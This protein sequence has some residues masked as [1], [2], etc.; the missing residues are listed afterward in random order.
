[1]L[2]KLEKKRRYY[3]SPYALYSK[4]V[5]LP[6]G[7]RARLNFPEEAPLILEVGCGKG[8][9]SLSVARLQPRALVIGLDR[10]ADRLYAAVRAAEMQRLANAYFWQGDALLLEAAFAP[11]EAS[12]IWLVHPDP[13]PKPRQAKHRLTHPRFLR[14][15]H[16]ILRPG[17]LLHLRT[18]HE[19]LWRYSEEQLGIQGARLLWSGIVQSDKPATPWLMIET[20][21]QRKKGGPTYYLQATWL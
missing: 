13:Y 18:D 5:P 1:M 11:G 20:D 9:F 14:L 8:D 12:E 15:Y 17:G 10:K 2:G 6:G 3:A 7:W 4:K 19:D 16:R 21:F